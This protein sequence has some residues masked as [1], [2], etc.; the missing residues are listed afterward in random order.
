M[1]ILIL[2]PFEKNFNLLTSFTKCYLVL[3]K[4]FS[5]IGG[6]IVPRQKQEK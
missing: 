5:Q 4:S 6:S 1:T 3:E 2:L